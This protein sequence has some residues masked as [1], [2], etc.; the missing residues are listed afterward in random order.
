MLEYSL[1]TNLVSDSIGPHREYNPECPTIFA[2]GVQYLRFLESKIPAFQK[3]RYFFKLALKTV[4][5][6]SLL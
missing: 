6:E 1:S 2:F 4:L 5:F 3:S